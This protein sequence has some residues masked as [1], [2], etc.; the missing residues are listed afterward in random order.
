MNLCQVSKIP[1]PKIMDFADLTTD[2]FFTFEVLEVF[3]V[4]F[5]GPAG[6]VYLAISRG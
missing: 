5:A 1:F 3:V 4:R 6:P 2:V